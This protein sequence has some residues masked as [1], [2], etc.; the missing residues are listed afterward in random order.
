M[1]AGSV[2][3]PVG[4][5]TRMQTVEQ[6]LELV[7]TAA[8]AP[9]AVR[10]T[11]PLSEALGRV[12]AEDVAMDHDV[13]PFRRAAM[14]GFALRADE[15]AVGASFQVRGAVMAGDV[16]DGAVAAGQAVRIMTGAPVPDDVDAV[17]PF[18]WTRDEG[19]T[20]TIERLPRAAGNIVARGAHVQSG[21]VVA[22]AGTVIAPAD[23]GALAS[24]GCA[25]V[26]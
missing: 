4:Y 26:V 24:A 8:G 12:L 11:V 10:E 13:P 18:E 1:E 25:E 20:V 5:G 3:P 19:E 17:V 16:L 23:L 9:A 6:A 21:D 7:R 15:V 2:T 14:D 22:H